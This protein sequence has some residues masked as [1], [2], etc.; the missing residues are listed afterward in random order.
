MASKIF[1]AV[2]FALV[3]LF[4]INFIVAQECETGQIIGEKYC[5]IGGQ[6]QSLKEKGQECVNN[7]ECRIQSC[8]DGIC[9]EKFASVAERTSLLNDIVDFFSG[10]QCTP[11]QEKCDGTKLYTCGALRVWE[12]GADSTTCGYSPGGGGGGGGGDSSIN[13]I[14]Y[15]PENIT[16]SSKQISLKVGD[17]NNKARYW[18]YSLNNGQKKDF[19]YTKEQTISVRLGSNILDIY[20]TKIKN[21]AET[22]KSI[23]FS[24]VESRISFYCGD[25]I[26]DSSES[27]STCSKDCSEPEPD[28][29]CGNSICESAL[30]ESSF[31]CSRDCEAKKPKNFMWLF[32]TLIVLLILIIAII[33]ILIYRRVK[34]FRKKNGGDSSMFNKKTPPKIPPRPFA[35]E[36]IRPMSSERTIPAVSSRVS[37]SFPTQQISRPQSINKSESINIPQSTIIRPTQTSNRPQPIVFRLKQRSIINKP[38]QHISK[39]KSVKKQKPSKKLSKK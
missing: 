1:L 13:I 37:Q 14:I 33:I 36:F 7:Y 2:F 23:S 10:I 26:C 6:L 16:Y 39:P 28:Y 9:E 22:K 20:A 18:S 32:Y 25:G 35:R 34:G 19:D 17:R 5:D 21:G 3:F 12:G 15:S 30:G 27:A 4:L 29:T 24:V 8:V 38:I 11:G 31:N